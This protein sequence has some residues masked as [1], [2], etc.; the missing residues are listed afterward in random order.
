M[1]KFLN[2][3]PVL[4]L[5]TFQQIANIVAGLACSSFVSDVEVKLRVVEVVFLG[6]ATFLRKINKQII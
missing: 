3:V 5:T 4:D 6:N 1:P 2:T